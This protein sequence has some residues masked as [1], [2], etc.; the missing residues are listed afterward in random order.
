LVVGREELVDH[1]RRLTDIT[2]LKEFNH[3]VDQADYVL[4]VQHFENKVKTDLMYELVPPQPPIPICKPRPL[5]ARE[6]G[7][8]DE[9]RARPLA[10]KHST[11][12]KP[13]DAS[14]GE[15]MRHKPH[16]VPDGAPRVMEKYVAGGVIQRVV[17]G[18]DARS[19]DGEPEET[20]R[21]TQNPNKIKL[22][23]GLKTQRQ[24][25]EAELKQLNKGKAARAQIRSA[26]PPPHKCQPTKEIRTC[27]LHHR[28]MMSDIVSNHSNA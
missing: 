18:D 21:G 14:V 3:K 16:S 23:D 2:E 1:R 6:R 25:L 9:D 7:G 20:G 17:R 8:K 13:A 24:K 15:A 10:F 26:K 11:I 28:D 27:L 22:G 12:T 19:D 5:S 4:G